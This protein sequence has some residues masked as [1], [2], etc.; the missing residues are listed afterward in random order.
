MEVKKERGIPL[1]VPVAAAWDFIQ[2]VEAAASCFPGASITER[3]GD[4]KFK[5][6]VRL[7]LGPVTADFAGAVEIAEIDAAGHRIV[8][9]GSGTDSISASRASMELRAVVEEPGRCR[10]GGGRPY[11]GLGDRKARDARRAN[12]G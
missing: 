6:K 10:L 12:D 7:K 3:L 9:A 2:D 11:D 1:A 4:T 5:G 8:V